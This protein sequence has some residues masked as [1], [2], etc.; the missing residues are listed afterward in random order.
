MSRD[1]GVKYV[2]EGGL[3]K[4]GDQIRITTQLVDATTG[5]QLWAERYD[6]PR[7]D[8]FAR[9]DQIVQ[10]IVTTLNLE[11][12]MSQRVIFIG[13][14]GGRTNNADAYDYYLRG[15]KYASTMTQEDYFESAA[16]VRESD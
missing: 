12:D 13:V 6:C 9:Q 14:G 5:D 16:N 2:L 8:F 3:Q 11:M 10:R 15:Q 4:E 7:R 1:L